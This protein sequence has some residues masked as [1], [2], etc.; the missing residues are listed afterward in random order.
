[1]IKS[2]A[3]CLLIISNTLLGLSAMDDHTLAIIKLSDDKYME[4]AIDSKGSYIRSV[5][6]VELTKIPLTSKKQLAVG[7]AILQVLIGRK[8]EPSQEKYPKT[9]IFGESNGKELWY[10]LDSAATELA[11]VE[12]DKI[13][14][15]NNLVTV[16]QLGAE[17]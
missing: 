1:M 12:I 16:R 3:N 17:K 7:N 2:I 5:N 14:S 9:I 10:D 15:A 13:L 6:K 8:T 4:F 11:I